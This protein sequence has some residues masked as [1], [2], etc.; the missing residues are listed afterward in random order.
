MPNRALFNA[1][2]IDLDGTLLDSAPDLAAALNRLLAQEGLSSLTLAQVKTMVGDGVPT[3]IERGFTALGRS[4]EAGDLPALSRRFIED[5]E[6]NATVE[7]RPYP[8]AIEVM[9]SLNGDGWAL[10]ICTNKPEA[11][12]RQILADFDL[13][14]LFDAVVGGDSLPVRKPDGGHLT[15]AL[16]QIEAAAGRAPSQAVMLGDSRNDLLAGRNAGLPV[17]LVSHGYGAEPAHSLGADRVIDHFDALPA[18]LIE[19][20]GDQAR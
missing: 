2:L 13:T 15:G 3:L 7:T 20:L 5:Y 17:I 18:A 1:L 6:A 10:A 9:R 4:I 12:T 14:A 16:A 11:P 8:G 19:L